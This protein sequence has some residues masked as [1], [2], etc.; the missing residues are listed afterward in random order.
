MLTAK[1]I[2]RTR[3][4]HPDLIKV[5]E[6]AV[7]YCDAAGLNVQVTEGLRDIERQRFL[8]DTKKSRTMN[9]RHLTGHAIDICIYQNNTL[10]WSFPVFKQAARLFYRAAGEL[11]IDIDWGGDWDEDGRSDD[12]RLVDGPH[13]ELNRERYP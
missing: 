13:F 3:G 11:G 6:L 8:V 4:V 5:L 12:E 9:S 10:T 2:A 7:T 1:S